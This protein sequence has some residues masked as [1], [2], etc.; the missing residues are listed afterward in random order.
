MSY[1]GNMRTLNVRLKPAQ[2]QRDENTTT[3]FEQQN[4]S[5]S[6]DTASGGRKYATIPITELIPPQRPCNC[7]ADDSYR[8]FDKVLV[9]GV[10]L[11]FSVRS[12]QPSRLIVFAFRNEA[13]G[14]TPCMT[15][16][17][18][19][20]I[21][22]YDGSAVADQVL[23]HTMT[24]AELMGAEGN[25]NSRNLELHNGPFAT[26]QR[27]G[28]FCWK[29]P[30]Q[31]AFTSRLNTG[32]CGPL[33][34]ITCTYNG[35]RSHARGARFLKTLEVA[36]SQVEIHISLNENE[37][38]VQPNGSM[39]TTGRPLELFIGYDSVS[40][41]AVA[42]AETAQGAISNMDMEVYYE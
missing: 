5:S 21:Q 17:R 24:K 11:R 4:W 36:F 15:A 35:S 10:T 14:D 30:D 38:F 13:R 20:S 1:M 3:V 8:T 19:F 40:F 22:T 12:T 28:S 6:A 31:S 37:S 7:E 2:V 33:G 16:T 27:Q 25:G 42:E 9:K 23:F 18:P 29:A 39:S 26:H 32:Q 34:K 41:G